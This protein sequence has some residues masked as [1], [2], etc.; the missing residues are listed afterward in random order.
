MPPID[1]ASVAAPGPIRVV[2]VDVDAPLP[3]LSPFR[4]GRPPYSSAWLLV[5]RS[6]RPIGEI[7]IEFD[8]RIMPAADLGDRLRA[9]FGIEQ[10]GSTGHAATSATGHAATSADQ[11][12]A[13][14]A[15]PTISVVVPSTFERLAMLERCV[16]ALLAQDYPGF[17]VIVV[18]NRPDESVGRTAL[19]RRLARDVRVRIVTE[20]QRGISAARNRGIAVAIGSVIACTD[21]DV[22]MERDWLRAIGRRFAAEPETDCVAGPVLPRELETPAQI[23]F[24]RS[25]SK[26]GQRYEPVRF[27]NDGSWRTRPLGALRGGRFEVTAH[28]GGS[29]GSSVSIYSGKF[30]MGANIAF[31]ADALRALGGFDEALG[32]GSP[33][34]GGEDLLAISR[35]MFAGR[36]VVFDPDAY[37]YHTHRDTLNDLERQVYAY[38]TGYTAMLCALFMTDPRHL[39]GF[40]SYAGR[41][42]RL[43]RRRS[44][45]RGA[46]DYPPQLSRAEARGLLRG[47]LL[48]VS[49]RRRA[50]RGIGVRSGQP[51]V[52]ESAG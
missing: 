9:V 2:R 20:A 52:V 24:E 50:R 13:A 41:A 47:P 10:T 43:A 48:Y 23:W 22:E 11:V 16:D 29:V 31:R 44:A 35:L 46:D 4:D 38:G 42:L 39:I 12:A 5:L 17:E 6:G 26:I 7:Q 1:V 3:D 45:D 37:V 28:S 36:Q 27:V 15:L 21:D 18:D 40:A 25:G 34:G 19:H 14:V 32:A 33:S 49:G 51:D 30:G 8:G